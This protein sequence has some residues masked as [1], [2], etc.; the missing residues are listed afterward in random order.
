MGRDSATKNDFSIYEIDK[1]KLRL[2]SDP[3]V[4]NP[5]PYSLFLAKHLNPEKNC[6]ALDMGC[7]SGILAIVLAKLGAGKVVAVDSNPRA[8]KLA[9]ENAALNNVSSRVTALT[10][11]MFSALGENRFD[12]IVSNPPSLPITPHGKRLPHF[13]AGE[14]GRDF[15][16]ELIAKSLDFLNEGGILEFVNTSL[17]SIEKTKQMLKQRGFHTEILDKC[18]LRFRDFYFQY[19]EWFKKLA[20]QHK[21]YF[22]L[23]NGVPYEI[24]YLVKAHL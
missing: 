13:F 7:G 12:L 2:K 10:S 9:E 17:I 1:H 16:D 5:T 23:R 24:L 14:D 21:A 11:N 4:L 8:T 19:Y 18:E 20:A 22:I 15:V 6:S 3:K